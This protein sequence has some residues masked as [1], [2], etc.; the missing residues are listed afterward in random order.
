[1]AV[2][3]YTKLANW[4]LD[5]LF[6]FASA[7]ALK[8]SLR[9]VAEDVLGDPSANAEKINAAGYTAASANAARAAATMSVAATVGI[10]GL[11]KSAVFSGT[12]NTPTTY[13]D[14]AGATV[15]ITTSGR[16]VIIGLMPDSAASGS[17]IR[18]RN[19]SA[20]DVSVSGEIKIVRDSTDIASTQY[21]TE[22]GSGS[23]VDA[24]NSFPPSSV[25]TIDTPAAGT[26]VYKI[27]WK[28]TETI[29]TLN[30][31]SIIN[32]MLYAYEL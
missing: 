12:L 5:D 21:E 3:S 7:N 17:I 1:M 4:I 26:Y 16:P 2:F 14:L 11:A 15:T 28:F 30:S 31:F 29:G 24:Q 25:F 6:G 27:Q 13:A 23:I 9:Y 10:G 20:S 22:Y 8:N 18:L 19:P 32:C